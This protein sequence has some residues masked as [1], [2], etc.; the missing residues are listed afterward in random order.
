MPKNDEMGNYIHDI[1]SKF[2]RKLLLL[3]DKAHFNYIKIINN[4]YVV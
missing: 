3:S 2:D 1:G 4:K